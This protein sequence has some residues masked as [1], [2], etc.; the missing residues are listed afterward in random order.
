MWPHS[1]REDAP[2]GNFVDNRSGGTR[3]GINLDSIRDNNMIGVVD[4]YFYNSL[5]PG[6]RKIDEWHQEKVL[7][8]S[9]SNIQK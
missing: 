7:E 1:G 5:I 3:S 8:A 9:R 6:I 4:I 2:F